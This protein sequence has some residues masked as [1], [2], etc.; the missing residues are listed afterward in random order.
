MCDGYYLTP[1]RPP[2]LVGLFFEPGGQTVAQAVVVMDY[3]NV[4]LM[5]NGLFA[6]GQ[7]P[8][9]SLVHPLHYANRLL[10]ARNRNQRPGVGSVQA[11]LAQV[12]VYRGLPSPLHD[13]AHYNRSQAQKA[14]WERDL[15]VKVTLR[16]LKYEYQRDASG[17]KATDGGG[18]P[19][20]TG[21]VEKGIDVLCALAVVREARLTSIDIVILA[22]QDSDLEPALDEALSMTCAKVETSSWYDPVNHSSRELRPSSGRK[23]WNTRLNANDFAAVRDTKTY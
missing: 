12:L 5:G 18:A 10:H 7:P 1:R 3:Q 23:I 19:I 13:S 21:K 4:H 11:Q 17:R 15:R 22:S 2:G 6:P 9:L 20:V 14:E 16:P 8:H